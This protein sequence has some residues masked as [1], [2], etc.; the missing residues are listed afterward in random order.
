LTIIKNL[1]NYIQSEQSLLRG[2]QGNL[3]GDINSMSPGQAFNKVKMSLNNNKADMDAITA[4]FK[5]TVSPFSQYQG[6]G[7]YT[8]DCRNIRQELAIL[9]DHFCFGLNFFVNTLLVVA[10]VSMM[11]VFFLSWAIFVTIRELDSE[12]DAPIGYPLQSEEGR[13]MI[14]ESQIAAGG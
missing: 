4:Q 5:N 6:Q 9:E 13:P 14:G 3:N 8:F 1:Q 2:L 11:L 12:S 7:I 10:S